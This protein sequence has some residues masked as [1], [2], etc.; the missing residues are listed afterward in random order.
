[1]LPISL[2]AQYY[3][4]GEV[5]DRHGDKLQNVAITVLSTRQIYHSGLMGEF[6]II[7]RIMDDTLTFAVEGYQSY[8][9]AVHTTGFL[10]VTLKTIPVGT[11][12]GKDRPVSLF[13]GIP[14]RDSVGGAGSPAG[15]MPGAGSLFTA[16]G[17]SNAP[18]AD[19]S[20]ASPVSYNGRMENP[21]L[22]QSTIVSFNGATRLA[23]YNTIRR[24]LDMGTIVPPDAVKIEE[25]MNYFNFSYAEPDKGDAFHCSSDLVTCPWNRAHQ[26]LFLTVSA[27]KADLEKKPPTNLVLL[28]DATGSMD[29]P[30]KLPL[31]KSGM[32]TLVDNL[33]D[34]D[35]VSL[36]V[37]GSNVRVML[38][39]V[40]GSQKGRIMTAIERLRPDGPSP[41]GEGMEMAYAVAQRQFI[42]GGN[43][44]V[45]LI[46]DG[47]VG[48][49][50]G[51]D[52][53]RELEDLVSQQSQAGIHLTCGGIG[54]GD[55]KDSRLPLLA[56]LGQG[57]FAYLD[58][59]EEVRQL[60]AGEL[61][62]SVTCVADKMS[63]TVDFDSALVKEYRLIGFDN[64]RGI[65]QDTLSGLE[66]SR[67]C[68]GHSLLALFELVPKVD[69]TG[70]DTLAGVKISY[71]LPGQHL[72][73]VISYHCPNQ[74]IPFDRS[75]L[76][77]RRAACIALFGMKLQQSGYAGQ[78]EWADI[79][80]MARKTFTGTSYL[81][82]DY[83]ALVDKARKI[84]ERRR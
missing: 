17:P 44:K 80:K 52:G 29:M 46:T 2:P 67:I 84:Y 19:S 40:P 22:P 28:I 8:T 68:S 47:D 69:S 32:R 81:D 38:A 35:T 13:R 76:N 66:G 65:P 54:M 71:C 79:E 63:I 49:G 1:V 33:R 18:T 10:Q 48:A 3:L 34:I 55:F 72:Q 23:S 5:R 70:A 62:S 61:D 9:T 21:F 14:A 56:E 42:P 26:L 15:M 37:Y 57:H 73:R 7:S 27:R 16:A 31:V 82:Y 77:L 50:S 30:D 51:P 64:K 53:E 12:A 39:G 60:L 6:G 20:T 83:I 25:M 41:G 11:V 74:L 36:V 59:E 4:T 58:N 43:N 75:A 78:I 45:V 24:F